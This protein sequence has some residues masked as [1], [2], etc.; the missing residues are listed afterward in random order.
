MDPKEQKLWEYGGGGGEEMGQDTKHTALYHDPSYHMCKNFFQK[1]QYI[2]HN[3]TWT[4][5]KVI[6]LFIKRN[7]GL[8]LPSKG[9]KYSK[10]SI[11][12]VTLKQQIR[13]PIL[14]QGNWF[15]LN[16]Y[17]ISS[18]LQPNDVNRGP[19]V[20]GNYFPL[21]PSPTPS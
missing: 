21:L 10:A 20:F 8:K 16:S 2:K 9:S 15:K 7:Q 1:T 11:G 4:I 12:S 14:P 13:K 5:V 17:G 3:Q 6:V 18:I 19:A